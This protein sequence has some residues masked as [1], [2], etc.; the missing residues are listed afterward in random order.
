MSVGAGRVV[1][2]SRRGTEV[3]PAFPEIGAGPPSCRRRPRWTASW[4]Y[5][6]PRNTSEQLRNRLQR[7]GARAGRE[8][9]EWPAHFVA[10]DLLRL[11]RADTTGWQVPAEQDRA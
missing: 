7:R 4:S 3:L 5:G 9:V 6:A 10:F 11:S 8:A 1:R 2:R